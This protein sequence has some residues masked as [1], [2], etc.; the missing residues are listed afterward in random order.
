MLFFQRVLS[1]VRN[2]SKWLTCLFLLNSVLLSL[3]ALPYT[4]WMDLP[5]DKWLPLSYIITT[6]IGLFGL[7]ALICALPFFLLTWLPTKVFRILASLPFV[8]AIFGVV[9]DT[10]IYNQFRIHISGF[11][12]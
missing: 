9:L 6:Q 8:I 1:R 4:S 10:Q 2:H 7:I 3:L 5:E 12:A 11:Y